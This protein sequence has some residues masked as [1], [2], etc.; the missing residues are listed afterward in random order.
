MKSHGTTPEKATGLEVTLRSFR[1]RNYRLFFGGQ[2]ISLIGTWMQRIAVRWLI[3]RITDSAFL[4][5]VVGFASE[6][7]ILFLT[8]YAG[9]L[10]DKLNRRRI[11]VVTQTLSMIQA[12]IL[13]VLVLT[14]TVAVWHIVCLSVFLGVV[15]AF[16]MPARHSF[17]IEMVEKRE[18]LGNAI[19]LNSSMVNGTQLIGPSIAG[20][21]I[22]SI[23]EGMCFLLNGV[24]YIAVILSLFAMKITPRKIETSRVHGLK[25]L[26]EG[27]FYSF[28]FMPIR[29]VLLLIALISIMGWPYIS[30]MPV[31]ARDILHG[32]PHILGF[33]MAGSGAGA[34]IGAIYLA[35]RRSVV[36]L[37]KWISI[38]ASIFGVGL[39]AFSLSRVFWFSFS[40]MLM[41]GFGLMLQHA[42]SNTFVQT[43]VDE[44][45]RGRVMSLY[46][47]AMRGMVPF[48]SLLYGTLAAK[49]GAPNTFMIGGA[50]CILASLLFAKQLPLLR[51]MVRPIYVKMGLASGGPAETPSSAKLGAPKD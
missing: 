35:S 29:S 38:A 6:I 42:S 8:P 13:A 31:F 39:I 28:R 30:L 17:L 19:A 2:S 45:K 16:D 7:P 40:L 36:G 44:D 1:H 48:G 10:A 24:S 46:V 23:G 20:L 34:L 3:Y 15:N 33:L 22:A 14:G 25:S 4:L 50:S 51:E 5:G 18:D 37:E 27:F 49:I 21:L 41:N 12:L 11:L 26:Q 47:I 32:G 9:V 43:V